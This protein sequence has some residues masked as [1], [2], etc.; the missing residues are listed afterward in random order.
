MKTERVTGRNIEVYRY[1]EVYRQIYSNL[2][3]DI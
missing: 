2:Q 1:L 3:V